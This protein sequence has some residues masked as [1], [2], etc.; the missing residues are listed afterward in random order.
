MELS[1]II[2]SWNVRAE[3]LD[4]LRSIEQ[5]RRSHSYEVII[6]DNASTDGTI[7]AVQKDLDDAKSIVNT[8]NCGFTVA[9]NVGV[10][11]SRGA[12]IL[13]LNPYRILHKHPLDV[14]VEFLD[15]HENVGTCAPKLP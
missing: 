9:D 5:N 1:I 15:V 4:C 13:F 7:D 11:Q 2:V 14:L 12:Y 8:E 10:E 3:L 6:G